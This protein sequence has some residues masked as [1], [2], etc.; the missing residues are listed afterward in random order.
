M[1]DLRG[2]REILQEIELWELRL[3]DLYRE[4][5]YIIRK[6]LKPPSSS[7]TANYT[8]MPSSGMV[9]VNI[10]KQWQRIQ[11]IDAMIEECRDILSL[12]K[13]AKKRMEKI[14]EKMDRLEYRVAYL[15]DVRK[16][17]L[18]EIAAELQLTEG[19]IRKVSMRVP[20]IRTKIPS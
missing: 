20:R 6:M 9:I 12:K 8:G 11:E 19:W 13:D 17:Q 4:R 3:Q 16:L 7:L 14:M 10:P 15:R 18:K 2:Y 1:D 5:R